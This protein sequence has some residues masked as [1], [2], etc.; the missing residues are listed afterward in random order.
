MNPTLQTFARYLVWVGPGL[1]LGALMLFLA[2]REPRLRIV[3]YLALFILLRD[4]MTPLGLWSFGTQGF[5]WMRLD[6]DPWFLTGFGLACLGLSLGIYFLDRANRP[7]FRWTRAPLGYGII[8]GVGGALLVVLPFIALYRHT[9]IELRGWPVPLQLLPF[10][11]TFALLG[12]LLEE[13]LFRGYV[14]GA[15]AQKMPLLRAGIWSGVVFA[16]CHI[17]LATT[18]TSV[19]YPLLLFTLWEGVIAGLVGAKGGVIPAT[20]THGGAIFLLTSGL[21]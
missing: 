14:L 18:V 8:W 11:F 19:G 13:A 16:F 20:L 5:F 9:P 21:I 3:L 4:A 2:R 17:Y 12:N 15:L 7:L 6:S 1:V 10:T